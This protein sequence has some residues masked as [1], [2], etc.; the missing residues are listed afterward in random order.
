MNREGITRRA[1][2]FMT[3]SS[4]VEPFT[5]LWIVLIG[6]KLLEDLSSS[7]SNRLA[8]VPCH[9]MLCLSILCLLGELGFCFVICHYLCRM[10]SSPC[11]IVAPGPTPQ[12]PQQPTE[13]SH[14]HPMCFRWP[15]PVIKAPLLVWVALS[16]VSTALL[17]ESSDM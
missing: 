5:C 1:L 3:S 10:G 6:A 12:C 9:S 14:S 11:W 17:T 7:P 16:C 15:G 2:L 13:H 8:V 4:E